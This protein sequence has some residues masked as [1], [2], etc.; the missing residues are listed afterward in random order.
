MVGDVPTNSISSVWAQ[1]VVDIHDDV[2]EDRVEAVMASIKMWLSEGY[3]PY[4]E[5]MVRR[6]RLLALSQRTAQHGSERMAQ[7][8]YQYCEGRRGFLRPAWLEPFDLASPGGQSNVAA[9]R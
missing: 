3:R 8:F 4:R 1:L 6:A 7:A 2:A 5:R 9:S